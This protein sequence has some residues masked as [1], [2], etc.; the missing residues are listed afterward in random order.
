MILVAGATGTVGREVLR[1]LAVRGARIRAMTREPTRLRLPDGPIDVVQADFEHVD[2]LHRA[3]AGVACRRR[4]G[5]SGSGMRTQQVS[6][7]LPM[8][9]RGDP[10]DDLFGVLDGLQHRD[11]SRLELVLRVAARG[12]RGA[13]SNLILVL[14]AHGRALRAAP[15]ARLQDGLGTKERR[16]QRAASQI[17]SHV[18]LLCQQTEAQ[19]TTKATPAQ[20]KQ[21]LPSATPADPTPRATTKNFSPERAAPRTRDDLPG[22]DRRRDRTPTGSSSCAP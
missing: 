2:S 19:T 21:A 1:L 15:S 17:V 14:V 12:S 18:Q 7:A 9:E 3:V 6:S 13:G 4:P 22:R 11:A 20:T 10:L 16:R 5:R 8:S